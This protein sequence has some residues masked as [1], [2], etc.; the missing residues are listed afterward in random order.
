MDAAEAYRRYSGD[1][2]RFAT[3]IVGPGDAE[4]ALSS[5]MVKVL[6][7]PAWARVENH[8]SYLY[9]AVLN[10]ARNEHRNRQ[11]R[12]TKELRAAADDRTYLPE[13][14][15]EV[16]AAIKRLSV[17]QRAVVV[18]CY[19]EDLHLEEIASCLGISEG[20]VRRHLARARSKLRGILH[21]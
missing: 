2:I 15:P 10:E 1:L 16:L 9:R 14:R 6:R 3:G 8:R 19:W 4:D 7:S 20:S 13:Y 21:E 11:R 18:L 17:R 12:W 5:A